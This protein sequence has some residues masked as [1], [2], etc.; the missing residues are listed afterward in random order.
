MRSSIQ[1]PPG[2]TYCVIAHARTLIA[3]LIKK[4]SE[5]SWDAD[6]KNLT[7]VVAKTW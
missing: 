1:E 5:P 4:T 2:C 7:A 3:M 6:K